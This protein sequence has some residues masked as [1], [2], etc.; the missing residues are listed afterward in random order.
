MPI[1]TLPILNSK[2]YV[3]NSPELAQSAIRSRT[4]SFEP[5]VTDFIEKMTDVGDAAMKVY[6]DPTFFSRW[7]KIV[8]SSLTGDHL[9]Q[10]NSAALQVVATSLNALPAKE[11][12]VSDLFVWTRDLLSL[13]S[14][15]SLL[16]SKNPWKTDTGLFDAYW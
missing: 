13:A 14:T 7:I 10:V 6:S 3:I 15:T 11:V 9:L 4:L 12:T 5:H 1:C 8:Y 2:I 16:G